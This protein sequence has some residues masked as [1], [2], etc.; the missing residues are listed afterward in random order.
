ML[1]VIGNKRFSVAV[2]SFGAELNSIKKDGVEM[3]WQNYDGSWEGHA[4]VLFPFCGHCRVIL[5]GKDYNAPAHGI[6]RKCE[7]SRV[8][9][10]KTE[11]VLKFASS[12][13]TKAVYPYDFIF[14][15]RYFVRKTT[16]YIDYTVEN[17]SGNTMYFGCGGHESFN[18]G[19]KLKDY[20]IEFEKEENLLRFFHNEDGILTGESTVYQKS[21]YLRF[22]DVPVDNDETLIF[23]GVKSRWCRL[24]KNTGEVVAETHFKGFFDLLF[25]RTD[26]AAYICMEPWTNLP[27]VV[28]DT[29]DFRK[30]A[31]IMP[32]DAGAKKVLKRKIVY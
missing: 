13:K 9:Q 12:E 24:V 5:D 11:L 22:K 15:V 1:Y 26:G 25:W 6:V 8:S 10:T 14:Y 30:K 16:L 19:A 31:G 23:K 32:L 20:Y 2:D 28:G 17:K 7:F 4:P 21:K 18:I 3:L 29:T 27:D